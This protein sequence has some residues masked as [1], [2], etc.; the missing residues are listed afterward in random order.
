MVASGQGRMASEMRTSVPGTIRYN[1]LQRWLLLASATCVLA[2]L[3][4]AA[5]L[6]PSA[7]G[8]GT[9]QQLGL[10]PCTSIVLWGVRCP[11]CG[12]TTSWAL[13]LRGQAMAAVQANIGGT[14]LALIAL[15]YV[16]ISCYFSILGR[17]SR[18]GWFSSALA[19]GLLG[20]LACAMTQWLFGL[21]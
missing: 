2:L 6:R 15:A 13:L 7:S 16:P 12:M 10:P 11:S 20:S 4:T 17:S 14:F 21:L 9:H 5:C 3:V 18:R 1:Q 19:V 8:L